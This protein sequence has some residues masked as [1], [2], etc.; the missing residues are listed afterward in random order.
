MKIKLDENLPA[1]LVSALTGLGHDVDTVPSEGLGGHEDAEIWAAAQADRGY[2]PVCSRLARRLEAYY[3][4]PTSARPWAT[5]VGQTF[6]SVQRA[7][8][9]MSAPHTNGARKPR[10]VP[11][12]IHTPY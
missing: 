6:L 11:Q 1:R 12:S 9:G 4:D 3:A 2:S 8:T 10:A 5:C 7:Q